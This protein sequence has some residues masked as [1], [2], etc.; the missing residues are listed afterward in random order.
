MSQL[1]KI[2][3]GLFEKVRS[4]RFIVTLGMI[5]VSVST[6]FLFA[7][8]LINIYEEY[9]IENTATATK[10]S[11][12]QSSVTLA[13][14]INE[15]IGMTYGI[16]NELK[17]SKL[18]A[19]QISSILSTSFRLNS[20][21]VSIELFNEE[22]Q[23]TEYAP[24]HYTPKEKITLFEQEWYQE[25]DR[26]NEFAFSEPHVQNMYEKLYPWVLSIS[27]KIPIQLNDYHLVV[28]FNFQTLSSYFNAVTIGRRGYTYILNQENEI[29]YH[30][31][32]QMIH[33]DA[34]KENIEFVSDKTAGV[35]VTKDE[36]NTIAIATIPSTRWKVVGVSYLQ[37]S[38]SA[39]FQ[40][41]QKSMIIVFVIIFVLIVF[42]SIALSTYIAQPIIRMAHAMRKTEDNQLNHFT[43]EERFN[44][45]KQLSHSYNHL[46]LRIKQL[47]NQVKEEQEELRKSEMNV[48]QSQIN[49]HFLYNTLE[50]IL[51]MSERGNNEEA[52][53]MV[54]AL[55]KLLR[56][57]LSK[58]KQQIPIRQELEHAK[59]YLTI[60]KIRYK[61]QFTY[62]F[63]VDETL[64]DFQTI[65]IIIQPFLENS[66]YHGIDRMV[67]EGHIQVKLSD[68][69]E[70]ILIQ[71]IDDGMGMSEEVLEEIRMK[72]NSDHL[73]I[74]IRNVHQR[75]QVYFGKEYGVNI[76]SELDEGTTV[77]IIIPKKLA[78][79]DAYE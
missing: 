21:I 25:T 42:L 72:N 29:I 26:Y 28:N 4:L 8:L 59:N 37:D 62:S 65:K 5:V 14:D 54:S 31:Q 16:I 33:A 43:K 36:E 49:P 55:G 51:W 38:I 67:D 34:K 79:V 45:V 15:M 60:Q 41:I 68:A 76:E 30:P 56:I 61:N 73:G 39:A 53:Q 40:S 20:D 12:H 47:M 35:F 46:L 13:N 52:T 9:L 63:D 75:L 24:Q 57:S 74:G 6:L 58:G 50:S 23:L 22:G 11:V 3:Q 32:Q 64:L 18:E 48:L 2:F 71:I 1:M 10:Q 69:A 27:T 17:Y 77:N 7:F 19:D 66:L 70:N 44:E 78:E